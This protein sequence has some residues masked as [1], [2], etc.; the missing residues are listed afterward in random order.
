MKTSARIRLATPLD[1]DNLPRALQARVSEAVET[2]FDPISGAVL[3]RRRRRLGALVLS[4][5]TERSDVATTA[6]ALAAAIAADELRKLPWSDAARQFQARVALLRDVEPNADWPDLSD[7]ALAADIDWLVPYLNGLARLSEL[8]RLDLAAILRDRVG[9]AQ[10]ARLDK[11][12]PT[13]LSLPGGRAAIDYTGPVPT[14]AARA[15]AFYGLTEAPKLA[16]GR[17]A[18]L[19]SLLSPAMRPIAITADLAGFWKGG[20]ADARRDMRG[21]YPRHSWPE[22]P[23]RP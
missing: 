3:A 17:I 4:D 22:D 9:Y 23:A 6:A 5:R 21:R 11:E 1:P 10:A 18:L 14:A 8:D 2:G 7:V 12:L 16:G 15:Q 19:L 13:H 20:W